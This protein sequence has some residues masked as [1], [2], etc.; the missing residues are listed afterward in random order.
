MSC[1]SHYLSDD[2]DIRFVSHQ[3]VENLEK[4]RRDLGFRRE[5]K[6]V[7]PHSITIIFLIELRNQTCKNNEFSR[8]FYL[9]L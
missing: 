2:V 6:I 4:G 9:P 7:I 1:I 5:T 3:F 8:F